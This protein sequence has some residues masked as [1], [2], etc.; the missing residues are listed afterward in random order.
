MIKYLSKNMTMS[1]TLEVMT[2]VNPNYI[3]LDKSVSK[4]YNETLIALY[5]RYDDLEGKIIS[6]L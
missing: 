1:G 4:Y 2:K 5:D 3:H 6:F